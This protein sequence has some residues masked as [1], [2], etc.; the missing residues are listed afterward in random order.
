MF[1]HGRNYGSGVVVGRAT[2]GFDGGVSP[3]T[4]AG[5]PLQ[6]PLHIIQPRICLLLLKTRY[7]HHGF[8]TGSRSPTTFKA[9]TRNRAA[10]AG[11]ATRSRQCGMPHSTTGFRIMHLSRH[12][13]TGRSGY[14]CCAIAIPFFGSERSS[15]RSQ[16]LAQTVNPKCTNSSYFWPCLLIDLLEANRSS[17][18][19]HF[20]RKRVRPHSRRFHCW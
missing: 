15:S 10:R 14:I 13:L 3:A 11:R 12:R 6:L 18:V 19:A 9:T 7:F 2:L 4:L 17:F 8:W 16:F 20:A 1:E 5:V